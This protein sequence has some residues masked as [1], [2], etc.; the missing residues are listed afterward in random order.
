[1]T[2]VKLAILAVAAASASAFAARSHPLVAQVI[3]CYD[4]VCIEG[5]DGVVRCVE[6]LVPCPPPN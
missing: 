4:V 1:M 3:R 6:K 2:K 5:S